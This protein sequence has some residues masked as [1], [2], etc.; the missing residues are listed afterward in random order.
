ML[1]LP[2]PTPGSSD[3]V[4]NQV[5]A[6][7]SQGTKH[8]Y[9]NIMGFL[10][11]SSVTFFFLLKNYGGYRP[12]FIKDKYYSITINIKETGDKRL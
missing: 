1:I 3:F 6:K 11:I 10:Q 8:L 4:K 2:W 12:K 9:H 5:A 7:F